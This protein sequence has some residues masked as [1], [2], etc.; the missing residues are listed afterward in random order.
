MNNAAIVTGASSGIGLEISRV[1]L[2]LGYEVFGIGRNFVIESEE[3]RFHKIVCDVLDTEKLCD[4]VKKIAAQNR[5]LVLVNNAGTAYYGL[6]EELNA[7]KI[8]QMVRTNLEV[9]MILTCRLLRELKKN[10]GYVINISSVTA[11]GTNPHGCA[12]GATK[13]GLSSFSH[14]LFDE[15]RKYGVKVVTISPDMTKTSLYRN[16]DFGE[17]DEEGSYLMPEEV[18]GAVE[19]VLSQREGLIISDITLKPQI[20]R[21]KRK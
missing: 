7:K 21:I 3:E 6:H 12:Y 5:V 1:L 16:A 8:Q 11:N 18:A 10:R 15:V 20:H 19:Y 2:R 13:A 17:G 9:P 4:I 14:S